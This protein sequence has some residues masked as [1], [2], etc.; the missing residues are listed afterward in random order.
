MFSK[1]FMPS[2]EVVRN[3]YHNKIQEEIERVSNQRV[4]EYVAGEKY[5]KNCKEHMEKYPIGSYVEYLGI[6]MM[7]VENMKKAYD[8]AY[9]GSMFYSTFLSVDGVCIKIDKSPCVS[10]EWANDNKVI[11]VRKFEEA[12]FDKLKIVGDK[13]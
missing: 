10:V 5:T 2:Y 12:E 7:V 4:K 11:Q 8:N 1:F 9:N 6:K 3:E 13:K